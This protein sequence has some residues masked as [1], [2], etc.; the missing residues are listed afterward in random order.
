MATA[1]MPLSAS[2]TLVAT[3]NG[4][5]G[6]DGAAGEYFRI[7][8]EHHRGHGAAGGKPGDEHAPRVDADDRATIRAIICRIEQ[9]SPLSRAVSSGLNQLKQ[10]LA[11]FDA[12]C[13]RH[14]QREAVMLRQRRP[15]G[16]EIVA[17]RGLA[18]AMQHHDQRRRAAKRDR[19]RTRTSGARPDWCQNPLVSTSGL[20]SA[21]RRF[22]P[23]PQAIETI[24]LW[25]TSQKFDIVGERHRQL[26][27]ERLINLIRTK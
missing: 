12:C 9:A 19:A 3:P 16:A 10:P 6:D 1:Y 27:D 8:R 24:Q 11:L 7:G 2:R 23:Y 21:G 26:L 18:A 22:R 17:G 20:S 15:A 13:S 4:K 5:P 14:Q 25:Q